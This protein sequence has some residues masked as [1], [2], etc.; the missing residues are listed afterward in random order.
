M[1]SPKTVSPSLHSKTFQKTNSNMEKRNKP[2]QC[3]WEK[4]KSSP[5]ARTRQLPTVASHPPTRCRTHTHLVFVTST[6]ARFIP[7]PAA[8]HTSAQ[9]YQISSLRFGSPKQGLCVGGEWIG[10]LGWRHCVWSTW[11]RFVTA[12]NENASEAPAGAGVFTSSPLP[13][14][15]AAAS[16]M[17]MC[18]LTLAQ[19]LSLSLSL[20]LLHTHTSTHTLYP[21]PCGKLQLAW[22]SSH[23][24]WLTDFRFLSSRCVVLWLLWTGKVVRII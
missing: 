3:S 2:K 14:P 15:A 10:A 7:V 8:G 1:S 22:R 23:S 12:A 21:C 13:I 5:E 6:S 9:D 16:Q 17:H 19:P 11:R 18:S 24:S 4:K 20:S